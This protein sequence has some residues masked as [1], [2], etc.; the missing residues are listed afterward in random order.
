MLRCL[1]ISILLASI[2]GCGDGAPPSGGAGNSTLA[3]QVAMYRDPIGKSS[4]D[5][6]RNGINT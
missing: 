3:E 4:T 2:T 1:V 5:S 6:W